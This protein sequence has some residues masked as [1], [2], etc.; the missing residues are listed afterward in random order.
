MRVPPWN[1]VAITRTGD[2][3]RLYIRVKNKSKLAVVKSRP[4]SG[5][6]SVSFSKL[7]AE[8]EEIVSRKVFKN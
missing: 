8:A 5:L 1:F 2:N 4:A 3:Q 6:L 7:K